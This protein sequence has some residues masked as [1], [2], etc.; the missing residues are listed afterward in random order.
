MKL[1]PTLR[2]WLR[3]LAW[4]VLGAVVLVIV[5][6]L[7][8]LRT[9]L[10]HRLITFPRQEAAWAAVRALRQPVPEAGGWTEYRGILHSHSKISHDSE[11]PPEEIL[12]AMQTAGLD[13]IC[14]SDHAVKGRA[15]FDWQWRG[16]HEGRLFIP[17][18]ELKDGMMPFGVRPGVVLEEATPDPA[19]ARQIQTNGG[20]LFYAHSE[21]PRNWDEPTLTGMEIYNIHSDLKRRPGGV[22]AML[23]E[24]LVNL[25]RHPESLYRSLFMRPTDFL[26]HWDELNRTRHLTG[27]AGNDCHQNVGLRG[28]CTVSNT[29]HIEDTSPRTVAEVRLGWFT[30]PLARLA[31]GPLEPGRRLFHVQ[32]DPYARSAHFV[33][34]HVL[35]SE[36][37]EAAILDSLRAGRVFVGFDMLADARG[38]RWRAVGN[39]PPVVMGESATFSPATRLEA[40]SPLPGRFTVLRDGKQVYQTTGRGI[41]WAPPG[42]GK[43]RVEVE[44]DLA[45]EWVP[46]IYANPIELR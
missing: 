3:R 13:F 7:V 10:Y 20:V 28:F 42:P 2:T 35:A 18:F 44:L 40:L 22:G 23:P 26:Q 16:L 45:G 17:G 6:L 8:W 46:W 38:F 27:I 11:V 39:G 29:L 25:N 24:I 32:L 36:L 4:G 1:P 34:T 12:K 14:L 41:E 43:Y 5:A 15:D 21:E 19:L 33:N 31:F 30:R 37:G 9:A